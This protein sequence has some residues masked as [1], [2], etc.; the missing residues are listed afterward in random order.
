M[1]PPASSGIWD[2]WTNSPK[3]SNTKEAVKN[4][5]FLQPLFSCLFRQFIWWIKIKKTEEE[6][7]SSSVFIYCSFTVMT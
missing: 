3:K 5:G 6:K 2:C 7:F 4:I 1:W